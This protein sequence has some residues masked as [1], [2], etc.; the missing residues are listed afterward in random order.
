MNKEKKES[1]RDLNSVNERGFY[2]EFGGAFV[3]EIL[4]RCVTELQDTYSEVLESESFQQEFRSLL[5]DYAGRPSQ[6]GRAHV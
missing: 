5:V 1:R 6:I 3:P 2:G 4:H